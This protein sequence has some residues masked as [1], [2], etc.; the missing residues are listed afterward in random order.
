MSNKTDLTPAKSSFTVDTDVSIGA[1]L[2]QYPQ[3]HDF[4]EIPKGQTISVTFDIWNSGTKELKYSLSE[5]CTWSSV[6]PQSGS[7]TS[8]HDTITVSIDTTDMLIG[9][10]TCDI[11][12]TSNGGSGRFTIKIEVVGPIVSIEDGAAD[13]CNTVVVPI[14]I[15]NVA[16]VSAVSMW[17]MYD[18]NVVEVESIADGDFGSITVHIDNGNNMTYLHWVSTTSFSGSYVFAY[19]ALHAVGFPGQMSPLTLDVETVVGK[20]GASIN[21]TVDNGFFKLFPL[22]TPGDITRDGVVDMEDVKLVKQ[23]WGLTGP[24]GWMPED[25]SGAEGMPDGSIDIW[26]MRFIILNWTG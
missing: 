6:H 3:F 16:N 12:I 25:I 4:G 5:T 11:S 1:R 21:H 14:T 9:Q 20:D 8:E 15:S 18:S 26:D 23:K 2:S 19:V 22:P 17:L 7:A 13:F 24:N 10:H